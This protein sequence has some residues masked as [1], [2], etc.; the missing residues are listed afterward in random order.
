MILSYNRSHEWYKHGTCA[1]AGG[2]VKDELDYFSKA[3]K[4]NAA[5]DIF[6]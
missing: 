1:Y 4:I 2:A 5:L 6:K 3:L